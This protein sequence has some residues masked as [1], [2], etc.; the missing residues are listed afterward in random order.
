M[1]SL[2]IVNQYDYRHAVVDGL[3][4]MII[5]SP[6]SFLKSAVEWRH[7]LGEVYHHISDYME[8][9][10]RSRLRR[11]KGFWVEGDPN[12]TVVHPE[13]PLSRGMT[14]CPRCGRTH[15]ITNIR[16]VPNFQVFNCYYMYYSLP[17]GRGSTPTV[18]PSCLRKP[19]VHGRTDWATSALTFYRAASYMNQLTDHPLREQ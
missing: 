6:P 15:R 10:I 14:P 8:R 17:G 3:H 4:C 7:P 11:N 16:C 2:S 12:I 9:L 5:G 19:F 18:C 13:W 1:T